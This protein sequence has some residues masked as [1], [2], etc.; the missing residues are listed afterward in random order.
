MF[1]VFRWLIN[2]TISNTILYE[3]FYMHMIGY[4]TLKETI[5]GKPSSCTSY[6]PQHDRQLL[7]TPSIVHN[8]GINQNKHFHV[9]F[10]IILWDGYC[11]YDNNGIINVR[12]FFRDSILLFCSNLWTRQLC[13]MWSCALW[14]QKRR[15]STKCFLIKK[16]YT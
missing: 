13:Q 10:L 8:L 12:S 16:L 5:L 7:S 6:P 4:F 14:S 15:K 11:V 2:E 3:N 9:I 1:H